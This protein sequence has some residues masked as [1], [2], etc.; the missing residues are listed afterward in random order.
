MAA[1]ESGRIA[2]TQLHPAHTVEIE[3]DRVR[4]LLYVLPLAEVLGL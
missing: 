1:R 2:L 4:E 3:D